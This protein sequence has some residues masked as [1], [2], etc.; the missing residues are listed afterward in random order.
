MCWKRNSLIGLNLVHR[1]GLLSL[2]GFHGVYLRNYLRN[3]RR[4]R[5]VKIY[6][7]FLFGAH[8]NLRILCD[9]DKKNNDII[10][11]IAGKNLGIFFFLFQ[12]VIHKMVLVF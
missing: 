8:R 2:F 4:Q 1:I 12:R 9:T 11:N 10:T 3:K 7:L 5:K 6:A